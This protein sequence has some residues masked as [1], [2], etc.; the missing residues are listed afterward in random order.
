MTV[1]NF[2]H[3]LARS[4]IGEQLLAGFRAPNFYGFVPRAGRD[5]RAIGAEFNVG[6]R[7]RMARK[8]VNQF[9]ADRIPQDY[10]GGKNRVGADLIWRATCRDPFTVWAENNSV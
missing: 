9:A 3:G 1:G 10:A 6:D 7:C 5:A 8:S 4:G 2:G